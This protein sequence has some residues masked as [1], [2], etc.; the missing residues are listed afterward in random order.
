MAL[1]N[2]DSQLRYVAS[3]A[4]AFCKSQYGGNGLITEKEIGPEIGWR[5][6]FYFSPTRFSIVAVE[7]DDNL[8]PEALRGAAHEIVQYK[9]P[10]SIFQAC[11]LS[12]YQSDREQK[13]INILRK[14]GIGILTVD[15]AGHV[16]I[17]VSCVPFAQHI[18]SD[19]LDVE[20]A[21]LNDTLKVEFKKAHSSYLANAGQGLQLAGQIVEGLV[22]AIAAKAAKDRTIPDRI[23]G[24]PLSR[25]DLADVIDA[26][27]ETSKFKN[28]RAALGLAR[29]FIKEFRNTASHAP[30]SA[31]QAVEKI[32]KCKV[33]FLE[34]I[35]VAVKLR[36]VVRLLGYKIKIHTT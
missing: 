27:Y 14:L 16:D 17:Q 20:L 5:P 13:K 11:S 33:G 25:A 3:K 21:D 34:A 24:K 15:G 30:R 28:H 22:N 32:K 9:T 19:D 1:E 4:L 18:S 10:I 35:R 7:V 2:L 29:S 36:E 26:L 23:N 12:T 6:T 8:Y 31:Q